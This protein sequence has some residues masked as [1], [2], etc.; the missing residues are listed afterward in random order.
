MCLFWH[1]FTVI[2]AYSHMRYILNQVCQV[3]NSPALL[4]HSSK[5]FHKTN[6]PSSVPITLCLVIFVAY[7]CL[8]CLSK[9][10][11]NVFTRS[12]PEFGNL[13]HKS[14]GA[15]LWDVK[16]VILRTSF[17]V[18]LLGSFISPVTVCQVGLWCH[19]NQSFPNPDRDLRSMRCH[20]RHDF[21]TS[22]LPHLHL[23]LCFISF[24]PKA[25]LYRPPPVT[26]PAVLA[27]KAKRTEESSY[28]C[29]QWIKAVL[30]EK[31][32]CGFQKHCVSLVLHVYSPRYSSIN[33][34]LLVYSPINVVT[35]H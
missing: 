11:H 12:Q 5:S 9:V 16:L 35:E 15:F 24:L 27:W 1:F 17:L 3:R 30:R 8:G 10:R 6:R 4:T 2:S 33:G 19:W 26:G 23:P 31:F 25:H 22:P 21:I 29:L 20:K 13:R 34:V 32:P 7:K 18:T 14:E 28:V